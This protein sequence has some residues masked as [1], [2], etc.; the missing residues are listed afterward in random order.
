MIRNTNLGFISRW[1]PTLLALLG[2]I[3]GLILN[4]N[5]LN[6]ISWDVWI[7]IFFLITQNLIHE[8]SIPKLYIKNFGYDAF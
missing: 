6:N 8:I 3:L 7:V 4:I 2:L 5:D 1:W